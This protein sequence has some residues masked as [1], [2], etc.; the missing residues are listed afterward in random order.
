MNGLVF[1]N[2][3]ASVGVIAVLILRR[4]FKNK[5]FSKVFVLLWVVVIMRLLLPFEISSG[6][7]IYGFSNEPEPVYTRQET[8]VQIPAEQIP[9]IYNEYPAENSM[10]KSSADEAVRISS[11][12]IFFAVWI[13][14]AILSA[15]YYSL[16]HILSVNKIMAD[17]VPFDDFPAEFDPKN[18][19]FFQSKSLCSPLSFGLLR[20]KAVIPEGISK[21]Q[22]P[23]VLLHEQTHIRNKDALLKLAALCALCLNWFN[24]FAY[25]A[26]KYLERDMERC[27]DERVLAALEKE[28]ASFYANTILDFAEKESLSI[29]YFSAASLTERIVSIMNNKNKKTYAP[30]VL[31]VFAAMLLLMTACG[32]VPREPEEKNSYE[33]LAE[34]LEKAD[35]R[36]SMENQYVI[37]LENGN[38]DTRLFKITDDEEKE[39][40]SYSCNFTELPVE[41]IVIKDLGL[42]ENATAQVQCFKT[43]NETISAS[44]YKELLECG[45]GVEYNDGEIVVSTEKPIGDKVPEFSLSIHVNLEETE[46]I[47]ENTEVFYFG[48][49]NKNEEYSREKHAKK[50][51]FIDEPREEENNF[52]TQRF[53]PDAG[54][55]VQ[56]VIIKN[57]GFSDPYYE[58]INFI[59]SDYFQIN[60][61]YGDEMRKAGFNVNI[62]DDGIAI[63][64]TTK[65]ADSVSE[66]FVLNI[67][68]DFDSVELEY[69][70]VHVTKILS[71][72]SATAAATNTEAELGIDFIRPVEGGYVCCQLWGYKGHVGTDYMPE[73]GEGSDIFAVADGTVVKAKYGTTGY[74]RYIILDHG[75]GIHTVYAHCADLFVKEGDE[76]KAGDIIASVGSSGNSTGTHLHFELRHNGMYLD[77]EK[78]I[79]EV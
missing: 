60:A 22:L 56:K 54:E 55:A 65:N 73:N 6:I 78:Y 71:G 10:P 59:N 76:V 34:I 25:A 20:P 11:K 2:I 13:F 64:S 37:E 70:N 35:W 44:N 62:T 61:T 51:G 66:N 45:F 46:I 33:E 23:F 69:E 1:A 28:K 24:P 40:Y 18:T 3:A 53:L 77:P 4:F 47:S 8:N 57:F 30:A 7:S 36:F 79:P 16:K 41:R 19:R 42:S 21:E 32:T 49:P 67:F 12:D 38:L 17:A 39:F 75:D 15:G 31:C 5:V 50:I 27:C 26:A 68:A 52:T 29:S 74:G 63:I 14:G 9:V 58:D 72:A 48:M 43:Y